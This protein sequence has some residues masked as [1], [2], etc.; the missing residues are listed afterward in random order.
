MTYACKYAHTKGQKATPIHTIPHLDLV[1]HPT[2][3]ITNHYVDHNHLHI[4]NFDH[5]VD[6]P[7]SIHSL[8]SLSLDTTF[9]TVLVGDFNLHSHSWSPEGW[10]PS[11]GVCA[12]KE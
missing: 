12:F 6:N 3:L 8:I 2:I 7:S 11:P 9:S 5:D 1:Q 4:I 10:T